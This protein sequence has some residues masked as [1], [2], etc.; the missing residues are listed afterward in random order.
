MKR[1]LIGVCGVALVLTANAL[2]LTGKR[3]ANNANFKND[4]NYWASARSS[5]T[6]AFSTYEIVV[7]RS[8]SDKGDFKVYALT[9]VFVTTAEGGSRSEKMYV[10]IPSSVKE[11]AIGEDV[12]KFVLKYTTPT[13]KFDK[14]KWT[15]IGD[16]SKGAKLNGVLICLC[17]MSTPNKNI[18]R[19]FKTC[20]GKIPKN[21][22][23]IERIA[24]DSKMSE[25]IERLD[26]FNMDSCSLTKVE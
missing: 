1:I 12:G 23:E 25:M 4:A 9:Y 7:N 13:M 24:S 14:E 15:Y 22:L 17:D 26:Y 20:T 8:Q 19:V 5:S 3:L 10:W 21:G 11:V 2:N 16:F 6:E 18:V